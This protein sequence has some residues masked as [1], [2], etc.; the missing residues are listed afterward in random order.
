[1]LVALSHKLHFRRE[2]GSK[3]R[4]L[5][6]HDDA[7]Q[8]APRY[9]PWIIDAIAVLDDRG[10]PIAE[11]CRRIGDAA[12]QMG[13]VR[14]SYVHLRRLILA[15]RERQDDEQARREE[16]RRIVAETGTRFLVGLRVDA[17]EVE[18][19]IRDAGR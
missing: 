16:I 17:Y 5:D 11:I 1:V 4:E 12:G 3:S 7:M 18:A 2:L 14:P 6:N 8:F 13:L 15:E 9:S 10:E 19:R